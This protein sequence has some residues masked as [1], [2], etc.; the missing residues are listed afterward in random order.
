LLE[1]ILQYQS[2]IGGQVLAGVQMRLPVRFDVVAYRIFG[3]VVLF[4]N[5]MLALSV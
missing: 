1:V 3:S 2:Y 5:G 4:Q